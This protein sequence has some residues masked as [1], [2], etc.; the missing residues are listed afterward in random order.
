MKSRS[1]VGAGG[2]DDAD[3]GRGGGVAGAAVAA[4]AVAGGGGAEDELRAALLFVA[5]VAPWEL[6]DAPPVGAAAGRAFCAAVA[7]ALAQL[8]RL[9][10]SSVA[11]GT[12]VLAAVAVEA[13]ATGAGAFA[14]SPFEGWAAG[15]TV[16]GFCDGAGFAPERL[17]PL[18]TASFVAAALSEAVFAI[19][20]RAAARAAAVSAADSGSVALGAALAAAAGGAATG[21]GGG[22][23]AESMS[24]TAGSSSTSSSSG[25]AVLFAGVAAFATG[26]AVAGWPG[27]RNI[28]GST[29]F[30]PV[31]SG[32][33]GFTASAAAVEGPPEVAPVAERALVE[34][35]GASTGKS[36]KGSGGGRDAASIGRHI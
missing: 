27:P 5:V 11:L 12:S 9:G 16:G 6:A 28:S 20:T 24:S 31:C 7:R 17:T 2:T 13:F 33:L 19:G 23:G 10:A 34:S 18:A 35:S 32:S 36:G 4:V 15:G 21:G 25:S 30:R 1:I 29:K 22:G 3:D 26:T 8:A 14:D